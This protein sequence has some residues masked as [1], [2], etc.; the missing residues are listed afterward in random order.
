VS[1][2]VARWGLRARSSDRS[3][4]AP[5]HDWVVLKKTDPM[6]AE[7]LRAAVETADIPVAMKSEYVGRLY[8]LSSMK[9]GEVTLLV[10]RE[11]LDEALDLIEN[12]VPVDFPE[13]DPEPD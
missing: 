7:V 8:G 10:P 6:E 4:A 9:L 5:Q 12:S 1:D 2:D 11:R 13:S 3:D